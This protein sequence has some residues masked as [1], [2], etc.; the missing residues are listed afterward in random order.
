MLER[1]RLFK[2]F[3]SRLLWNF[4][5]LALKEEESLLMGLLSHVMG[6]LE[7][8]PQG[9]NQNANTPHWHDFPEVLL[10]GGE[11]LVCGIGK[12]GWMNTFYFIFF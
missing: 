5:S 1:E 12:L 4:I 3:Y 6:D 8:L 10:P 7:P 9:L 2:G 11:R